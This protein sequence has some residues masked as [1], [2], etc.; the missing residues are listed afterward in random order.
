[1]AQMPGPGCYWLHSKP[2]LGTF[3][4]P[5]TEV[6]IFRNR[7]VNKIVCKQLTVYRSRNWKV[8]TWALH[9]MF[10]RRNSYGGCVILNI[11]EPLYL[12]Q[13]V[14]SWPIWYPVVTPVLAWI[15]R[16]G[17]RVK[18]NFKITMTTLN[19]VEVTELKIFTTCII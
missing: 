14:I 12:I 18:Y 10:G 3:M 1:M 16:Q 11:H 17:R 15:P 5:R 13:V 8:L 7:I 9:F 19:I 6:N 2:K 4:M